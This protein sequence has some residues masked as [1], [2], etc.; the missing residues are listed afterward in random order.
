MSKINHGGLNQ[1]AKTVN[2]KVSCTH[3]LEY[4]LYTPI[5]RFTLAFHMLMQ[6]YHA[7]SL[8][9]L[10]LKNTF[11]FANVSFSNRDALLALHSNRMSSLVKWTKALA[12]FTTLN[13]EVYVRMKHCK[14]STI[15]CVHVW[16]DYLRNSYAQSKMDN[17]LFIPLPNEASSLTIL[18]KL[19]VVTLTGYISVLWKFQWTWRT[20]ITVCLERCLSMF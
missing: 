16:H 20:A 8:S 18:A 14:T 6:S 15:C 13:F 19:A 10:N 1:V 9:V 2:L 12:I 17:F 11:F 3:A 4:I 7:Y 5:K